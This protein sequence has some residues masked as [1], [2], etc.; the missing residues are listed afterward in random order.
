[1]AWFRFL[2]ATTLITVGT[3]A[4]V[5]GNTIVTIA[6]GCTSPATFYLKAINSDPAFDGK[7]VV[8]KV[9]PNA[10]GN[11]ATFSSDLAAAL[12][13]GYDGSG[14]LVVLFVSAS[15]APA[16]RVYVQDNG[17]IYSNLMT[18]ALPNV[19]C[20]NGRRLRPLQLLG[21]GVW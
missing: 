17:F 15:G 12:L 16:G 14:R 10:I 19:F 3:T 20:Q 6:R 21:A 4:T 7:W 8:E 18:G 9:I 2:T 13:W 1:M 5:P 11:S